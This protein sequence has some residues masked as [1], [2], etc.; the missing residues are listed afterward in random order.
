MPMNSVVVPFVVWVVERT[1]L[2]MSIDR[3]AESGA[4]VIFTGAAVEVAHCHCS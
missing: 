2:Q 1:N 3:R 4:V